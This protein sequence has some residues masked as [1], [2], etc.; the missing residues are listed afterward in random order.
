MEA[1]E[2]ED[3]E[4]KAAASI[5]VVPW[6]LSVGGSGADPGAR[7]GQDKRSVSNICTDV[8]LFLLLLFV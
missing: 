6:P 8:V 1:N 5:E 3:H 2:R 7:R 4:L